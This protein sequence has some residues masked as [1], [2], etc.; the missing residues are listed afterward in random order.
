MLAVGSLV[1]PAAAS[2]APEPGGFAQVQAPGTK[3]VLGAD[4]AMNGWGYSEREF[5]ASGSA[6]VYETT[7]GG[8]PR[9][10]QADLPYA[11]RVL[12]R[13]PESD[14][15]SGPPATVVVELLNAASGRDADEIWRY[16]REEILREG[17]TWVGITVD[18]A[19]VGVLKSASPQRYGALSLSD[20]G[21][22]WDIVSQV[23]TLLRDKRNRLNP[24]R[25]DDVRTV[26]AAGYGASAEYLVSYNNDFQVST[27]AANGR[28]PFEGYL[29]AGAGDASRDLTDPSGGR[30]TGSERF[31]E[32]GGV[33]VLRVQS[34]GDLVTADAIRSRQADDASLRLW[35]FAGT[36]HTDAVQRARL[37]AAWS[38]TIPG[39]APTVCSGTP[40]PLPLRYGM[41]AALHG[42]E[43]WIQ[44]GRA[45]TKA[46]RIRTTNA[47]VSR[48]A[49]GNAL[50]GIRLPQIDAPLGV[51]GPVGSGNDTC[52]S[53]GSY[54][55][56]TRA[57]LRARYPVLREYAAA[58][59][60]SVNDAAKDRFI[61]R[62]D[63]HE[64]TKAAQAFDYTDAPA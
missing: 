42:L 56:F 33:P 23:A 61:L 3:A 10:K 14:G 5:V 15:D 58:V 12:I 35:E 17:M 6:S 30:R 55:P 29:I 39:F 38:A 54:A 57:A 11:T 48:D 36:A 63:T 60:R 45:P 26:V 16:S 21:Q 46:S 22:V 44:D 8:R 1:T 9:V 59:R 18:P 52:A 62:I 64:I 40:N 13:R 7:T 24:L 4:P 37:D 49:S 53:R 31:I 47:G 20:D 43:R 25:F 34:E 27:T 2:A 50:G 41:N 51:F 19:A 32:D 28:P